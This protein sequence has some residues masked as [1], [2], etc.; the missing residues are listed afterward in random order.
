MKKLNL[1]SGG[2]KK[3]GFINLDWNPLN[4]PDVAHDLNKLPYPFPDNS[5]DF[6][7][8]SHVLEHLDKPFMVMKE[9][10]RILKSDGKLVVKVP[11]FS[12]GFTH[13]EH[14]HGFDVTFPLY[15]DKKFAD[16]LSG[17][18][19]FEF[20]LEKMEFHWL[21]FTHLLPMLGYNRITIL[22]LDFTNV[23][24]SFFA[25]LSP[26]FC[27][28]IWCYWVGGFEEIEFLFVVKK[29]N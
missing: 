17:Y 5:F 13:A 9:L 29:H 8:A 4:N 1:G 19:G 25:N 21:A 26:Q 3:E 10:H 2:Y 20:G 11:H 28:R 16:S 27:S 23:V 14:S 18:Q 12:R 6:I 7:E 15:F 22:L 24:I